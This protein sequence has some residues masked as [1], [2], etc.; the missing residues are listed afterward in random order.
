MTAL[1]ISELTNKQSVTLN[2][3]C[4]CKMYSLFSIVCLALT[5]SISEQGAAMIKITLFFDKKNHLILIM[6]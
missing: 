5:E 1:E 2:S 4:A 6:I 3:A